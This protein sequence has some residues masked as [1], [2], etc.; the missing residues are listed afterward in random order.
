M[1]LR[2]SQ[3]PGTNSG[4]T[5]LELVA[6][7]VV[8]G[9]I[10]GFVASMIFYQVDTYDVVTTRKQDVQATRFATHLMTRE[11]REIA[12]AESIF[13]VT[14]DS[15][16]FKNIQNEAITY[17]R[18][19][20]QLYRNGDLLV[21]HLSTFTLSY[22]D[23]DGSRMTLPVDDRSEIRSISFVLDAGVGNH[24]THLVTTVTP[25]NF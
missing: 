17:A 24:Q 12:A 20:N 1:K 19:G 18:H 8:M 15:I 14:A 2:I 4:F 7:M 25:R 10:T 5:L 3:L 22:I 11:L 16:R 23:G 9:I 21:D 6:A 13:V